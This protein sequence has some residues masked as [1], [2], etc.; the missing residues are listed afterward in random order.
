MA[1]HGMATMS[2]ELGHKHF[3]W[4]MYIA[5]IGDDFLL[6]CDMVDELDIT[7]NSK[8]GIQIDEKWIECDVER[9]TDEKLARVVL[10][11]NV[12][13][14]ANSEI[15]LSGRTERSEIID[16]RYAMLQPTV[17]DD[18]KVMVAKILIDPF[19]K[20]I[21]V[22][23]VNLEEHPVR[24]RRNY[25]LGEL[26]AVQNITNLAMLDV[27]RIRRENEID[28]SRGHC[29]VHHFRRTAQQTRNDVKVEVP[30]DW[31]EDAKTMTKKIKE[32]NGQ[33][34]NKADIPVLP[35]HLRDLF[36]RSCKNITDT[37]MKRN[38]AEMI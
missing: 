25:L 22:R 5:P 37:K 15:I 11:E 4:E 18:R 23:I 29:K 7:I 33:H 10:T 32:L 12:T 13:I 1:T 21:P 20:T 35:E 28:V 2:V 3:T 26:H 36:D 8:R 27:Q 6:G 9:E 38:I 16:T 14:P 31:T 17:E 24:L 19:E 34:Q 30:S